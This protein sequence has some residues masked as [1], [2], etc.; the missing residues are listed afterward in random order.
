MRSRAASM[1]ASSDNA[2]AG[3]GSVLAALVCAPQPISAATGTA[4]DGCAGG[5]A[6]APGYRRALGVGLAAG[7]ASPTPRLRR[8]TG[9]AGGSACLAAGA[10]GAADDTMGAQARSTDSLG[11]RRPRFGV[12]S[13]LQ[14]RCGVGETTPQRTLL[15]PRRRPVGVAGAPIP[16]D[17]GRRAVSGSGNT[18]RTAERGSGR[19]GERKGAKPACWPIKVAVVA[20][21]E[22]AR[23]RA[24]GSANAAPAG[25]MSASGARG[26]KSGSPSWMPGRTSHRAPVLA[27]K[28]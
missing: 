4:G 5:R 12:S 24:R 2:G 25:A 19:G 16:T 27:A 21:L 10:A 17:P 22:D 1:A 23:G 26:S 6:I 9:A 7:G 20:A 8:P 28:P 3:A 13:V 18:C 11:F 15:P 14:S